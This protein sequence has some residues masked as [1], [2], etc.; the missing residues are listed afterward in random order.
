MCCGLRWSV[1][2]RKKAHPTHKGGE[3][4]WE[5]TEMADTLNIYDNTEQRTPIL[6]VEGFDSYN[7]TM[8]GGVAMT[9]RSNKSDA[10][11]IPCVIILDHHPADS[12]TDVAEDQQT[13]QTLTSR[14]GT[15]GGERTYDS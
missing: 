11:H 1:A 2:V 10:Q 15:G 5:L 12:R 13:I 9:I 6:V 14:M 7:H 3:Q 8:T 4:G